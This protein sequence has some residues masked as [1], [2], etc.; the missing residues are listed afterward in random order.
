MSKERDK[1]IFLQLGALVLDFTFYL[2]YAHLRTSIISKRDIRMS[3]ESLTAGCL[4]HPCFLLPG[5]S[6]VAIA[7]LQGGNE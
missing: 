6:F 1:T 2:D 5:A 4:F 3:P 7:E